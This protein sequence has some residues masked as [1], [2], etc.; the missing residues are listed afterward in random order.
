MSLDYTPRPV[1]SVYLM[2]IVDTDYYKV[3]ISGDVQGRLLAIQTSMPF[4]VVLLR[5]VGHARASRVEQSIHEALRDWHV[6]GEWF[7]GPFNTINQVFDE[8][9]QSMPVD[10]PALQK[11]KRPYTPM[12]GPHWMQQLPEGVHQVTPAMIAKARDLSE[13][14][15]LSQGQIAERIG[16]S[17]KTAHD[18][19]RRK[20]RFQFI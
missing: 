8:Y 16:I 14:H 2:Q 11:S 13:N 12:K 4:E 19:I 20:G 15:G 17:R 3:G 10:T 1:T 9:T 7:Q 18:I 5:A 6:R